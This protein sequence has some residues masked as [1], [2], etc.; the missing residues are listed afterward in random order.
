V[1]AY[2][3]GGAAIYAAVSALL[4]ATGIGTDKADPNVSWLVRDVVVVGLAALALFGAFRLGT[5]GV[6][7]K[8]SHALVGM[9]GAWSALSL[10][11]MH[12]FNLFDIAHG[13]L[14]ADLA[15]HGAGSVAIAW[16]TLRLMLKPREAARPIHV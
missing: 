4:L 3:A 13:E 14:A 5:D 15:F 1:L 12:A 2:A 16:G 9:G 6:T 8:L 10:L 11:D 7:D